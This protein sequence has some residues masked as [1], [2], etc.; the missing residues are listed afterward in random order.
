MYEK[1]VRQCTYKVNLGRFRVS[2]FAVKKQYVFKIMSVCLC[3]GLSYPALKLHLFWIVSYCH[4]WPL[5]FYYVSPHYLI[6]GTIFGETFLHIKCV[7]SFPLQILPDTFLILRRNEWDIIINVHRSSCKVPL[8]L[9]DFN[10]TWIFS[11]EFREILKLY[12][13]QK[14]FQ[15]EQSCSKQTSRRTDRYEETSSRYSQFCESI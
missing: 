11:K 2:I 12:I 5:W 4:L 1:S 15:W 6:N 3:S 10:E 13:W 9:S 7:F 8:F 14:F